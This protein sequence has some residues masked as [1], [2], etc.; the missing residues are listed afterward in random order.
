MNDTILLLVY[1]P[2]LIYIYLI[3]F[4][5]FTHATDP[6]TL[7]S[8]SLNLST[9]LSFLSSYFLLPSLFV[10]VSSEAS[11]TVSTINLIPDGT[12][13]NV[14]I[15]HRH[16][17]GNSSSDDD[18]DHHNVIDSRNVN[19]VGYKVEINNV[20]SRTHLTKPSLNSTENINTPSSSTTPLSPAT[21]VVDIEDLINKG[22]SKDE[23]KK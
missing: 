2:A 14:G 18:A 17:S 3:L 1:P 7:V 12:N 16:L 9:I 13:S 20:K 19:S 21:V 15:R 6:S 11:T 10:V 5:S 4:N 8:V 23:E 22:K